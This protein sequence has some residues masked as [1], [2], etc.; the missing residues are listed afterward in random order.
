MY[1]WALSFH[2][3][4]LTW[5]DPKPPAPVQS[6][7]FPGMDPFIEGYEWP[8][9]HYGFIASMVRALVPRLPEGYLLAPEKGITALDFVSGERASYRP[10]V[11]TEIN[12]NYPTGT[13]SREDG[14]LS[15]PTVSTVTEPAPHR[16]ITIRMGKGGRLITAIELLSPANKQGVGLVNYRRKRQSLLSDNVNLIEIDL[17][18]SG[19]APALDPDWPEGTYRVQVVNPEIGLTDFWAIGLDEKLPTIGVPLRPTDEVVPLD[20]QAVFAE[21]YYFGMYAAALRYEA[22]ALHPRPSGAE[23]AVVARYVAI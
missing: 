18:R 4:T 7:P 3:K 19:T 15:P 13:T 22:D 10:D 23:R 8:P 14:T 16:T 17:L 2:F 1:V 6:S 12:E 11:G 20:L 21:T 5:V 9:F